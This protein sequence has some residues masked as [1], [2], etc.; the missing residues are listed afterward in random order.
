MS[1]PETALEL[2]KVL[3]AR[4]PYRHRSVPYNHRLA[5]RERG[6]LARLQRHHRQVAVPE[7]PPFILGLSDLPVW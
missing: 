4:Q 5:A 1:A 3:V 6:V 2:A 7:D